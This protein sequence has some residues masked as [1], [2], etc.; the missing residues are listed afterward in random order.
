MPLVSCG[1][2]DTRPSRLCMRTHMRTRSISRSTALTQQCST[3]DIHRWRP[4]Q[5]CQWSCHRTP[6]QR[7]TGR[8][9][10]L[11]QTQPARGGHESVSWRGERAPSATFLRSWQHAHFASYAFTE[12]ARSAD[13]AVEFIAVRPRRARPCNRRRSDHTKLTLLHGRGYQLREKR[14][15]P[16]NGHIRVSKPANPG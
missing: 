16:A 1:V 15:H 8:A 3:E 2:V 4:G 11:L 7:R 9:S 13:A 14:E 5:R 6:A 12:R 10:R